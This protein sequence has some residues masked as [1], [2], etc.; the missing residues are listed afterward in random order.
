MLTESGRLKFPIILAQWWLPQTTIQWKWAAGGWGGQRCLIPP[1]KAHIIS[2]GN[3]PYGSAADCWY[4]GADCKAR[5]A[6][7]PCWR[8]TKGHKLAPGK[9]LTAQTNRASFFLL[10]VTYLLRSPSSEN[11]RRYLKAIMWTHTRSACRFCQWLCC[12]LIEV[13]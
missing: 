1:F 11:R 9:D 13:L 4:V 12:G 3:S 5:A 2:N 7:G 6:A 10:H 8:V